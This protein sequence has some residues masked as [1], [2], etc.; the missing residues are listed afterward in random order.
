[1]L[2][3]C[4]TNKNGKSRK[5]SPKG[6]KTGVIKNYKLLVLDKEQEKK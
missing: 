3:D 5:N 1:M 4:R 6:P 2:S